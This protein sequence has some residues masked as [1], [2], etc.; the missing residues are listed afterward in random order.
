MLLLVI[1]KYSNVILSL[2]CLIYY[3]HHQTNVRKIIIFIGMCLLE[4]CLWSFS[5]MI[6]FTKDRKS[7]QKFM[8]TVGFQQLNSFCKWKKKKNHLHRFCA[9]NHQWIQ[10]RNSTLMSWDTLETRKVSVETT[11]P[12]WSLK[13]ATI[14]GT[15]GRKDCAHHLSSL[16]LN[17]PS[18]WQSSMF[19]CKHY[20]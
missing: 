17:R 6:L 15:P 19:I 11:T 8:Q 16:N 20:T 3:L 5:V 2:I 14:R 1:E 13:P 7:E 10:S 12:S 18:K 9:S 4:T